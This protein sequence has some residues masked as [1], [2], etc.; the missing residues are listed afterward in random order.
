MP[1]GKREIKFAPMAKITSKLIEELP[2]VEVIHFDQ[3]TLEFEDFAITNSSNL[4]EIYINQN[5]TVS[6]KAFDDL[7]ADCKVIRYDPLETG[8]RPVYL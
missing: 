7:P 2:N 6:S 3:A 5:A 1:G 4:K 8:I